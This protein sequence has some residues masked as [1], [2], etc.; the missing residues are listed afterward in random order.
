MNICVFCASS[1]SVHES[2]KAIACGLGKVMAEQGFSLVYGG[3]NNGLMGALASGVRESGGR[4]IGVI[5]EVFM[6]KGVVFD[7]CDE[8]IVTRDLRERKSVM[9]QKADAF[10]VL[11]G[12]FGTLEELMEILTLKALGLHQKPVVLL[13]TNEFYKYLLDFFRHM[14]RENFLVDNYGEMFFMA[15]NGMAAVLYI[16][17]YKP[18]YFQPRFS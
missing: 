18:G 2:Y 5:P 14:S 17:D 6:D 10:I 9:E 7:E 15:K 12:G 13:N 3:G 11:P 8:L 16:K 4:I 1:N